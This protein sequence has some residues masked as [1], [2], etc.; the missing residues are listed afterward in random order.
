MHALQLYMLFAR[1]LV[2]ATLREVEGV[3]TSNDAHQYDC[4][5][6]E[7][8]LSLCQYGGLLEECPIVEV[9]CLS[10]NCSSGIYLVV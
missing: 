10:G 1:Y 5:G 8:K 7:T 4:R 9:K 2:P 6:D 3:C